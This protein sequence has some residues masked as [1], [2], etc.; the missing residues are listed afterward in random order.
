MKRLSL[1]VL[2]LTLP[3]LAQVNTG[4]LRLRVTGP[5]GLAVGTTVTLTNEAHQYAATF[6]TN[7]SGELTVKSLP[8]GIYRIVVRQPG[9]ELTKSCTERPGSEPTR[10][11]IC[12]EPICMTEDG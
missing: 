1:L 12:W 3:A 8:Y 7:A 5:S 2:F 11:S 4:D 10:C 6:S 9:C